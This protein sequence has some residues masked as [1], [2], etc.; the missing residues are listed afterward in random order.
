[1]RDLAGAAQLYPDAV[2]PIQIADALRELIGQGNLARDQGLDT[3]P[4][5]VRDTLITRFRNGVLAGLSDTTTGGTRP[6]QRKAR[7]LLEVLPD[8]HADV[9]R[10]AHD[11]NGPPS[12]NWS[13][14]STGQRRELSRL[15]R[16]SAQLATGR[17]LR[18]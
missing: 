11:L 5:P 6:G 2:W 1:M 16:P 8:R 10:F 3:I 15:L 7:L 17:A 12:K 4:D 13:N 9:L 14:L 18:W